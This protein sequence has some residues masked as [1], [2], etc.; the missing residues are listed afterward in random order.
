MILSGKLWFVGLGKSVPGLDG[1]SDCCTID[2]FDLKS[3]TSAVKHS[4]SKRSSALLDNV[5]VFIQQKAEK[6]RHYLFACSKN[7]FLSLLI[8][9][10]LHYSASCNRQ[11]MTEYKQMHM[12]AFIF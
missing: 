6:V 11:V 7:Q 8:T 4:H 9:F 12:P 10:L 5:G 3:K 2:L 1:G